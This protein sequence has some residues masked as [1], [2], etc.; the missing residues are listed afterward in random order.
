L[1]LLFVS[2]LIGAGI[3]LAGEESET[4]HNL[5]DSIDATLHR[6]NLSILEFL[7]IGIFTYM[8]YQLGFMTFDS[9]L[10]Y[11]KLLLVI[12]AGCFIHIFIVQG[13]LVYFLTRTN[14][15]TFIHAVMPAAILAYISGNRYTAY[16]VLVEN[17]E[18]NLGANRQVMTF[19]SGLG[20][21]FSLSGSA[22]A[23]GVST[24]F[25]AQAYGLDLSIY[26]QVI[27]VLLI[28]VST[29]KLDGLQEGSLILL[30]VVLAYIVKLPA[31]GY[32]ILLSITGLIYQ[33]ES[34]VNV[35]GNATVSYIIS[36][37]ENAVTGVRLRDFI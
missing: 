23:A 3:N 30:S 12:V 36:S 11:F 34:V 8:G 32:A 19:V 22:I 31:E 28:T 13:L 15:F 16:P 33:I 14:P 20:T 5:I 21:A 2:F 35:V 29:L 27:I 10:P 26:L 4:F 18:H 25:I 6:I 1:S 17:L 7:P 9:V 37:S 24:M